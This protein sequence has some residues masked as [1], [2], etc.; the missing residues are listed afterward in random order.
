MLRNKIEN[1]NRNSSLEEYNSIIQGLSNLLYEKRMEVIF[2][3]EDKKPYSVCSKV[4]YPFKNDILKFFRENDKVLIFKGT[5]TIYSG[6]IDGKPY[7]L[8]CQNT[9][10]ESKRYYRIVGSPHCIN[11]SMVSFYFETVQE[12]RIRIIKEID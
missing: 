2:Y 11:E 10:P 3:I 8:E 9:N 12:R 4:L 5:N 6:L 7:L 1:L